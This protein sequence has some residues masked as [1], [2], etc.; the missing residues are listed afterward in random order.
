MVYLTNNV[1]KLHKRSQLFT[2][3][4]LCQ[5][6]DCLEDLTFLSKLSIAPLQHRLLDLRLPKL[7]M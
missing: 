1:N 3:K 4:L 7:V 6:K 2:K 5:I